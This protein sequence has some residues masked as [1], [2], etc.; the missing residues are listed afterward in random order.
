MVYFSAG[1]FPP[2]K[3]VVSSQWILSK[4]TI[5]AISYIE[6]LTE[7]GGAGR[8][9]QKIEKEGERYLT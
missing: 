9:R 6:C 8:Q 1:V 4:Q 2:S 7:D 3:T 5:G